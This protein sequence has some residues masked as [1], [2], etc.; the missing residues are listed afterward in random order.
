MLILYNIAIYFYVGLIKLASLFHE[1]ARKWIKG[2]RY[3]HNS[4]TA[5][6]QKNNKY[7]WVHASSLGEFEQGRPVI[8]T[9]REMH[10]SYKIILTFFSPSGYE[11]RKNYSMVDYVCYLPADTPGNASKFLDTI[12]PSIVFFIKYE[13]WFNYLQVIHKKQI[14]VYFFSVRF[15]NGQYFFKR[16]GKWFLKKLKKINWFFVQDE[17]SVNLL[18]SA[19]IPNVILSGDTRFDRVLGVTQHKKNFPLVDKFS[20][21]SNTI[22]AGSTWP[23]DED[24]LIKIINKLDHKVKF[25]IAPHEIHLQRIELFC[26]KLD[27]K[28]L[29]FSEANENNIESATVL[30]I[31]SIGL[32]LHL[33]QYAS[34]AYIGGGFGKSIHNIL[35]AA[36]FGAPVVFGPQYHKFQEA[37]DLISLGGAHTVKNF[38]E[39]EVAFTK[40]LN[41]VNH[42]RQCSEVCSEY[43]ISHAGATDKIM[44]QIKGQLSK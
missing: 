12:N 6:I 18:K 40:L 19:G 27:K 3:W 9:L 23:A 33:Y 15:R 8:E 24:M 17:N 41:D 35:E 38:E 39:L 5:V 4:L 32:L 16:Y 44:S 11:V 13:F 22:V 21:N 42:R 36:A 31:D 34:F 2:R 7:I 30:I 14:P 37:H 26:S 25:I 20:H 1:K 28:S 43:V 29:K 10:P